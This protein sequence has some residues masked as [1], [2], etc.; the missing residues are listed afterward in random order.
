MVKVGSSEPGALAEMA[1]RKA[2][3][4]DSGFVNAAWKKGI[5]LRPLPEPIHT[6]EAMVHGQ[7]V[8]VRVMQPAS[9][10]GAMLWPRHFFPVRGSK[11]DG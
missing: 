3:M 7:L 10:M 1:G 9:A 8:T 11:S 6:Y 2:K 4:T 5:A